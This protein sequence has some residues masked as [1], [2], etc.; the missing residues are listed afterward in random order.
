MQAGAS[1]LRLYDSLK[2][3]VPEQAEVIREAAELVLD[4]WSLET[5]HGGFRERVH[6]RIACRRCPCPGRLT[7]VSDLLDDVVDVGL[8]VRRVP[9]RVIGE[10]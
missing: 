8:A 3:I 4:G 10:W 5:S 9:H 7:R 6:G 1:G 2:P